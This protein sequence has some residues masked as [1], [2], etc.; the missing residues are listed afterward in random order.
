MTF[1][2]PDWNNE[3]PEFRAWVNSM[4][5][6]YWAKYDLGACRLGWHAARL[7]YVPERLVPMSLRAFA[8]ADALRDYCTAQEIA[9]KKSAWQTAYELIYQRH[10]D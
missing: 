6:K 1:T 4:P 2:E 9:G 8:S 5:D 10:A 7:Q 3:E